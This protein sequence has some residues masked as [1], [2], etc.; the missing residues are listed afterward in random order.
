MDPSFIVF[1]EWGP[2][3][4]PAIKFAMQQC[5]C[6]WA[7]VC[8]RPSPLWSNFLSVETS[9]F[10]R[11]WNSNSM[12]SNV[13]LYSHWLILGQG[14]PSEFWNFKFSYD[15]PRTL[16]HTN[17]PGMSQRAHKRRHPNGPEDLH[18]VNSLVQSA[19]VEIDSCIKC[20]KIKQKC[21]QCAQINQIHQKCLEGLSIQCHRTW[22]C[23]RNMFNRATWSTKRGRY[24][25]TAHLWSCL[26]LHTLIH[27]SYHIIPCPT[28]LQ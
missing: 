28:H 22:T 10:S 27:K 8:V 15:L 9:N 5:V 23:Y 17:R 14:P 6:V 4:L 3:L 25:S 13:F 24:R 16:R 21:N 18:A 12:I 1:S 11:R 2:R 26:S 20:A 7:C 19:S